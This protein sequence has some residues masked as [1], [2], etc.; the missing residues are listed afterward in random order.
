M[1]EG[2]VEPSTKARDGRL[3]LAI[4][5]DGVN[6]TIEDNE[7]SP[8]VRTPA[9]LLDDS[10]DLEEPTVNFHNSTA[11]QPSRLPGPATERTQSPLSS[12]PASTVLDLQGVER[13]RQENDLIEAQEIEAGDTT[14]MSERGRRAVSAEQTALSR[15][16]FGSIRM[17]DFGSEL[18]TPRSSNGP[19]RMAKVTVADADDHGVGLDFD[20]P[21]DIELVNDT[22]IVSKNERSS[23][24]SIEQATSTPPRVVADDADDFQFKFVD[25]IALAQR[26]TRSKQ[27]SM[28]DRTSHPPDDT[29]DA[30]AS[31]STSAMPAKHRLRTLLV[32]A[33]SQAPARPRKRLKMTKA[34]NVIPSLPTSAIRRIVARSYAMD[35]RKKPSLGKEHMAALEQATEWFFEQ[36]SKD[37]ATFSQHA[38]R[39]KRIT[40]E[41]VLLLMKRQRVLTKPGELRRTAKEWLPPDVFKQLDLPDDS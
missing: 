16:S 25:K 11:N 3:E 30:R 41:D 10:S 35:G 13:I 20:I 4:D 29:Q 17:D 31:P 8:V 18:E 36:A 37:L 26:R 27:D 32:S 7:V 14:Y 5:V 40:A 12:V 1:P 6:D 22:E 9:E 2:E 39:K 21:Y 23:L 38:G 24:A 28:P 34:G 15:Y 33:P 19:N